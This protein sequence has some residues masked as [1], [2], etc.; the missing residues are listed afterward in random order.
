MLTDSR[1][2]IDCN[3]NSTILPGCIED[4]FAESIIISL[5]KKFV[6]PHSTIEK[7][8]TPVMEL[9]DDAQLGDESSD[10]GT[11]IQILT[12]SDNNLLD[13]QCERRRT[14]SLTK[15]CSTGFGEE[16][17]SIVESDVF[18]S[19]SASNASSNN[20]ETGMY[21]GSRSEDNLL[22]HNGT[23]NYG[24]N[25]SIMSTKAENDFLKFVNDCNLEGQSSDSTD[26]LKYS[27]F[28]SPGVQALLKPSKPHPLSLPNTYPRPTKTSLTPIRQ[29]SEGEIK[30]VRPVLSIGSP[31][32]DSPVSFRS[33]DKSISLAS[34]QDNFSEGI[35][36]DM[37]PPSDSLKQS[38]MKQEEDSM[39]LDGDKKDADNQFTEEKNRPVSIVSTD[40][41][42]LPD[43]SPVI[44]NSKLMRYHQHKHSL[45]RDSGLSDSPDPFVDLSL[46]P[47]H[48]INSHVLTDKLTQVTKAQMSPL[49]NR[50]QVS[51]PDQLPDNTKRFQ[52]L[53]QTTSTNTKPRPQ[54]LT[55][56][57]VR[58]MKITP[59]FDSKDDNC[60]SPP[61]GDQI[62]RLRM[63]SPEELGNPSEKELGFHAMKRSLSQGHVLKS[64]HSEI[65]DEMEDGTRVAEGLYISKDNTKRYTS[66]HKSG[67]SRSLENLLDN[68]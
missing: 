22:Q 31:P 57:V 17:D 33:I 39:E 37:S 68:F 30:P 34:S 11:E 38:N 6:R 18:H 4:N 52:E 65:I 62:Q 26:S 64:E 49:V 60:L 41:I 55:K 54:K 51:N 2:W 43:D 20:C 53:L 9:K 45:S 25:G 46:S 10:E 32:F 50:N 59:S 16:S 14:Q 21:M 56:H 35:V 47:F 5:D 7:V 48:A 67:L 58:V 27:P 42:P 29:M 36:D 40:D 15:S 44:S 8:L 28:E 12:V 13:K 1:H 63:A 19:R 66:S 61:D 23:C 24:G 3:D